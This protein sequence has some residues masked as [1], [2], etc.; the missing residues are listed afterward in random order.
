LPQKRVKR[1]RIL[2]IF[3]LSLFSSLLF[4]KVHLI[5]AAPHQ[6][7]VL[8]VD[9]YQQFLPWYKYMACS[10]G[11]FS[12]PFW[13][14][15]AGAGVPFFATPSTA[16]FYPPN[17]L[18]LFLDGPLAMGVLGI[19]HLALAGAGTFFFCRLR[20]IG[21]YGSIFAGA[22]YMFS[23]VVWI[24]YVNPHYLAGVAWLP[25]VFLTAELLY[26][27]PSLS[28]SLLFAGVV[29]IQFF[30]GAGQFF[31]YTLYFLFLYLGLRLLFDSGEHS[32]TGV[33]VRFSGYL[34]FGLAVAVLL[35][36]VQLLPSLELLR[37]SIRSHPLNKSLVHFGDWY[38][39]WWWPFLNLVSSRWTIDLL[40]RNLFH[41]GGLLQVFFLLCALMA[42]RNRRLYPFLILF[43]V[44]VILSVGYM[45]PLYEYF[46]LLPGIGQSRQPNRIATLTAFTLSILAAIGVDNCLRLLKEGSR[47]SRVKLAIAAAL[48]ALLLM[49]AHTEANL[50]FLVGGAAVLFFALAVRRSWAAHVAI[51]AIICIGAWEIAGRYTPTSSH[52]LAVSDYLPPAELQLLDHLKSYAGNERIYVEE[53]GLPPY[54]FSVY[55]GAVEGLYAISDYHPAISSRM[56]DMIEVLTGT[57]PYYPDGRIVL[58]SE[59]ARPD[60]FNLFSV[61]HLLLFREKNVFKQAPSGSPTAKFGQD[62]RVVQNFPD[63]VLYENKNALPRAYL[64]KRALVAND[65]TEALRRLLAPSF[66][67]RSM[68]VLEGEAARKVPPLLPKTLSLNQKEHDEARIV[69]LSPRRIL[70]DTASQ[71]GDLLV[72]TD[73]YYPGWMGKVDGNRSPVYRA[74]Y[75]FRAIY[76]PPGRHEVEFIYRPMSFY[77]GLVLS[78]LGLAVMAVCIAFSRRKRRLPKAL[79]FQEA[80]P[81]P[82]S[83]AGT[84][85][86]F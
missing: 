16:V 36:C 76:V 29:A 37:G 46:A 10:L 74:N 41:D 38:F 69:S 25:V 85:A 58:T 83:S 84:R 61:R 44:S 55:R 48:L 11:N 22:G 39:Q 4:W 5:D 31:L 6:A 42:F 19:F 15:Y 73:S 68:V 57:K 77:V 65:K 43:I 80:S 53:R 21:R 3:L 45:T 82:A 33:K 7:R 81:I 78:L 49:L 56:E 64:V 59:A 24:N 30:S 86:G 28:R 54:P 1:L 32:G 63:Y 35:S 12:I 60:I 20:G 9:L 8:T 13:F 27:Q 2:G 34:I 18:Y 75:L 71:D 23:N 14:P 51:I 70:L 52:P 17:F 50:A 26:N 72:L 67:P 79:A 40:N 47:T 62:L 66:D